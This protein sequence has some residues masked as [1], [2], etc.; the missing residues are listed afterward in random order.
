MDNR[1][2]LSED[3]ERRHQADNITAD[4]G[5]VAEGVGSM[6]RLW[7]AAA[8]APLMFASVAHAQ[9]ATDTIN[10][11]TN[12]PV[13][14]ATANNGG[15]ADIVI[16][17]GGSVNPPSGTA[18]TLNSNN[19]VSNAGTIQ[20]RDQS[21]V[22]GILANIPTSAGLTGN[23]IN[24]G[25]ITLDESAS[26][27]VN[28]NT[29]IA[30]GPFA[31]TNTK[32]GI[33]V[34]G[35]GPLNGFISNSGNIAITGDNSA[36]ILIGAGGITG[37]LV[38]AGTI[39]VLGGDGTTGTSGPSFG[40][41]AIGAIGGAVSLVGD[42]N[43]TGL[44]ATAVALDGG[45]ASVD[46]N[47]AIAS[48][49]F[50]SLTPPTATT[51]VA[52]LTPDQLQVGGPAVSIGGSVAGG[53]SIDSAT[54]TTAG[55]SITSDGPAPAL[56]IGGP[57]ALTVGGALV[58]DGG[59]AGEGLYNNFNANGVQIGTGAAAANITNGIAIAGT[60][61]VATV[62]TSL[63]DPANQGAATAL[64]LENLANVSSVAVGG[65][66]SAT[67]A[68]TVGNTVTALQIDHGATLTSLTNNG[69]INASIT[70]IA[71]ALS[72]P[73]AAGGTLGIATAV[74]DQSGTLSVINN[75]G[76][77]SAT[78]TPIIAGQV[79]TGA[80]YALD[81]RANTTGVTVTQ[82]ANAATGVAPSIVG[83][84]LF[85]SGNA[86][87]DLEAGTLVGAVAFG[88]GAGNQLTLDNGATITGALTNT[89][90]LAANINSGT[91]SI[92]NAGATPIAMSTLHIGS[93]G[94][95]I[96]A[97]DP[98]NDTNTRFNVAGA[99]N[100]DSGAKIGLRFLSPLE[101]EATYTLI[102]AGN[103]TAS[104]INQ[105]LVG[106]IPY[107]L[108]ATVVVTP[109]ADGTVQIDAARRTAAEAGFNPAEAAAYNSIFTAFTKD[110]GVSAD[111]LSKTDRADFIHLYDQFLP[112]YAGGP[113]DTLV[114]GQNEIA[115][116]VADAPIKL[117]GEEARGWV[118]EIGYL[119]NRQESS[120]ANGY[121]AGGFGIIG[122][123]ERAHGPTAVGLTA[124]FLTDGVTDDRQ[125]P[126]S[127]L[128]STALEVGAYWR[129]GSGD[130]L[131]MHASVNGGYV[132]LS[133]RRLLFDEDSTGTTTLFRE[134]KSQWNGAVAS[135]EFGASYQ[136]DLGKFYLRPEAAVDYILLYESAFAEHGGGEAE[137]LSVASRM[138]QE[139][140][141]QA[142][143][144]FGMD[145]GTAIHWRP[146]LTLGWRQIVAGG[147]GNTT[148]QFVSGGGSFT[149]SPQLTDRGGL[150]ARL[151][152]RAGGP[153]ADFS[154]DA[155][156]EFNKD[157]QTYDARAVARFLF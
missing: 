54:A 17:T 77:I 136:M 46:I 116:A 73:P 1:A 85:G 101:G 41:H 123:V 99:A 20:I 12:T 37:T 48:T 7:V 35:A 67:S 60:L 104:D 90:V 142:D 105:S 32:Y 58:I 146:E 75:T 49:G 114:V 141:A 13:A 153:F 140:S 81:L 82:S 15:P 14:T 157:Y 133:N 112:D 121:R 55:G 29:G 36:G 93:A 103:L 19:N 4:E 144:V 143:M 83:D 100:L 138:N 113:F 89:G 70:G 131:N 74:S 106:Q 39:T 154:A 69:Q 27:Q 86:T 44:G 117:Q 119:D 52:D 50:R 31:T 6:K 3:R 150:L 59:V 122:G 94:Q 33:A 102:E 128:A 115:R 92:T 118:Q 145:F 88:D 107:L 62:A 28:Q 2:S 108:N 23:I 16:G 34:M 64:H 98:A 91:L 135:A 111:L 132:S 43:A 149:L 109:G 125:G 56:L 152:L 151:G 137:D 130:G 127:S 71:A 79:S 97:V 42:I 22:I 45:A 21:N 9:T 155:G 8:L 40:I 57:N 66:L 148:A 65:I 126:S 51:L 76:S 18:V 10:S 84:V 87:L 96:F 120:E 30:F 24:T 147:P 124:A 95:V 134:A 156:G 25:A 26:P 47:A 11:G 63:A 129:E 61:E 139:A 78:I 38:Q 5:R 110:P 68:S 53:I 80:T 72:G